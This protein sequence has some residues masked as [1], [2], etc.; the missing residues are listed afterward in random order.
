MLLLQSRMVCTHVEVVLADKYE[1]KNLNY[2]ILTTTYLIPPEALATTV[3][4]PKRESRKA[5]FLLAIPLTQEP[6][7][8]SK[9]AVDDINPALPEGP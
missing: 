9:T 2:C 3:F 1:I 7:P 6:D 4:T 8:W 5:S